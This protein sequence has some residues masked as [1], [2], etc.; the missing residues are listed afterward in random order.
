MKKTPAETPFRASLNDVV[1]RRKQ[2]DPI[3]T[4]WYNKELPD[5][6]VKDINGETHKLSDYKGKNII[7]VLWATW[8]APCLQEIPHIIALQNIIN[9]DG[10]AAKIL[11]ISNE[12]TAT[13]K[14]FVKLKNLNYTVI[15]SPSR[16]LPKPISAVEA[17]PTSF[18][19]DTQGR[20][21]LIIEGSAHLGEL[22][23]IMM[24]E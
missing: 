19:I 17:I 11:A 1:N 15:S 5:F 14:N 10:L 21:K 13:V 18:F 2:W 24:A 4:N 9:K 7:I 23:T 3:L 6:S 12:R 16:A 22:K 8:C 20:I